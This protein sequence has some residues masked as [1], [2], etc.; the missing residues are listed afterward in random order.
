MK[1]I[2]SQST[3]GSM[4]H[5]WAHLKFGVEPLILWVC[6][7][8]IYVS[9]HLRVNQKSKIWGFTRWEVQATWLPALLVIG[10]CLAQ[11]AP[12]R[13]LKRYASHFTQSSQF[14]L[15]KPSHQHVGEVASPLPASLPLHCC[16][17]MQSAAG[18]ASSVALS[19][20]PP[21]WCRDP[22][23]S[24]NALLPVWGEGGIDIEGKPWE[25][26]T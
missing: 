5:W 26:F 7:S 1:N 12:A 18:Q 15:L 21:A 16:E 19:C 9:P 22:G 20:A 13:C 10:R 6:I 14:P 24:A 25:T 4:D 8:D 17:R 11:S 23:W 3:V 2:N